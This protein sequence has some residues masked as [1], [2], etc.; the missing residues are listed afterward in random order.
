MK[1]L[2]NLDSQG[3]V[4]YGNNVLLSIVQLAALEI[5][6]VSSLV[7]K[8][9]KLDTVSNEVTVNITINVKFGV[10][11]ADVAFRIQSNIRRS[12]ETMTTHKA[13]KINITVAGVELIESKDVTTL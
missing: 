5:S 11:C 13:G 6:G 2:I 3:N 4:T 9:I 1:N 7:N 10:S 8:H 12:I